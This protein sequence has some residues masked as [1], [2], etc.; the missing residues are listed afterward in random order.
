MQTCRKDGDLGT[1]EG[2]EW[3]EAIKSNKKGA[4]LGLR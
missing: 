1:S 2:D 3:N 4:Y